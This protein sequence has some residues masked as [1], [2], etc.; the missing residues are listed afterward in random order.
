[1]NIKFLISKPK[2]QQLLLSKQIQQKSKV[3]HPEIDIDIDQLCQ[4]QWFK[5]EYQFFDLRNSF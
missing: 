3:K 2:S 1:M 5:D 4:E